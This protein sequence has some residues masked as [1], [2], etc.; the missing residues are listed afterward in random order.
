MAADLVLDLGDLRGGEQLALDEHLHEAEARL[1]VGGARL[2]LLE[3][4]ERVLLRDELLLDEEA[5]HLDVRVAAL[6]PSTALSSG[7]LGH[8][9]LL[10]PPDFLRYSIQASR[11]S[12]CLASVS[13]SRSFAIVSFEKV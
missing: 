13:S 8:L 9:Y 11:S 1:L 12:P 10:G 5:R 7:L 3:R 2:L 6:G 4:E